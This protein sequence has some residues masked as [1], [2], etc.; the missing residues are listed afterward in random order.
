MPMKNTICFLVVLLLSFSAQASLDGK[1]S[2]SCLNYSKDS[3][4][5][6]EF[7]IN[8]QDFTGKFFLYGDSN[9]Q[10]L[11][12]VVDYASE[13][14]YPTAMEMGPIDHKVKSAL[15]IV[16]KDDIKDQLNANKSCGEQQ[17]RVG[18]PVR[19]QGYESCGPI[20]VPA[21]DA[22]LFDMYEQSTNKVSFGAFPLLWVMKEGKRPAL[23]SRVAFKKK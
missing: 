15:M 8:G 22:I 7:S 1:Y 18:T 3:F 17:V 23:P 12:L 13:V 10:H 11:D 14:N 2:T 6:S 20:K 4:F 21:K 16:F 9:C 5:K 19:V